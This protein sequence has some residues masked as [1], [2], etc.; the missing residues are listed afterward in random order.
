MRWGRNG[1]RHRYRAAHGERRPN[2]TKVEGNPTL[3]RHVEEGLVEFDSP[4]TIAKELAA[5]GGGSGA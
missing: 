3:R 2:A 1:G 4:M 5:R